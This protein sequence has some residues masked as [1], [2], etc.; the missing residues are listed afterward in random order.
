MKELGTFL[1]VMGGIFTSAMGLAML[2][3]WI[4]TLSGE[5]K[6]WIVIGAPPTIFIIGL[7]L[8]FV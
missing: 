1:M 8:W 2:A 7:I 5:T 6:G 3:S 4:D